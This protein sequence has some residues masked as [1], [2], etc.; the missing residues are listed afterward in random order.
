MT[1]QYLNNDV[2]DVFK[3]T[4]SVYVG[5][6]VLCSAYEDQRIKINEQIPNTNGAPHVQNTNSSYLDGDKYVIPIHC[7]HLYQTK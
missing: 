3:I 6:N 4:L 1:C 7:I 2:F 5:T